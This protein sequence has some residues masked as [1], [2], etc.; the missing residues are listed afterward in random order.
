MVLYLETV[1][2]FIKLKTVSYPLQKNNFYPDLVYLFDRLNSFFLDLNRIST[3][4]GGFSFIFTCYVSFTLN[5]LNDI[6]RS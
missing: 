4:L 5:G 1:L 2:N 3:K 6:L